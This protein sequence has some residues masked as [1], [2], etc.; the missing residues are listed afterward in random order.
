LFVYVVLLTFICED[1][2][3]CNPFDYNDL[4]RS[5][6]VNLFRNKFIYMCILQDIYE[7]ILYVAKRSI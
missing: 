6:R 5:K 4:W 7:N 1:M 2:H 3:V